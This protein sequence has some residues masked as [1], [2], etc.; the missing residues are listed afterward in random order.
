MLYKIDRLFE[1]LYALEHGASRESVAPLLGLSAGRLQEVITIG[2]RQLE[3][4]GTIVVESDASVEAGKYQAGRLALFVLRAEARAEIA[5]AK[6][7]FAAAED[8]KWTA[9]QQLLALRYPER[10]APVRR[11]ETLS[12]TTKRKSRPGLTQK[13]AEI[14]RSKALGELSVEDG[15]A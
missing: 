8:G 1:F 12:T 13:D 15:D 14:I 4:P 9:A 5:L 11:S 3:D 6:C 2:K 10:W 7:L